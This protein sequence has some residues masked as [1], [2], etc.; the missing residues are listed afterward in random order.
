MRKLIFILGLTAGASLWGCGRDWLAENPG[1]CVFDAECLEG[2]RCINGECLRLTIEQPDGGPSLKEFGERCLANEECRSSYCLSHPRG[3]FCTRPCDSGCPAGFVCREVADP[4]GGPNTVALCAPDEN[5]LC[6]P[7]L[8]HR[9]CGVGGADLCL[10]FPE[11]RFCTRDCSAAPCPAGY[12]CRDVEISAQRFRQCLPA[13]GTC[14]CDESSAG[15]VRGCSVHNDLGE[16]FGVETC[17]P[18]AGFTGCS[19]TVPA[20]EEC[21]GLDDDCDGFADEGLD[22]VPCQTSNA[23]GT[24]TGTR[25]CRGFDGLYCDAPEPAAEI[26]N[27]LDD[28]C[29]GATDEDFRDEAG[30][31]FRPEH[32]GGCNRDCDALLLHAS[33]TECRRVGEEFVCR[34]LSCE[35]G[36]YRAADDS[37]CLPLPDTLCDP[38]QRDADCLG[39]GSLCLTLDGER[40]CGRDCSPASQYPPGCPAGYVCQNVGS[41]LQCQPQT[42]TCLCTTASEGAIRSCRF[43]TCEG[44]QVCRRDAGGYAWSICDVDSYNPEIC[45]GRD[46][47]CDGRTDEGF[48]NPVTG[49]YESPE[50]CGT[51]NN[52][53]SRYFV[54]ELDHTTGVCDLGQNPPRCGMGPCLTESEGGVTYEWVNL[55]NDP[56]NG[57]ECRRRLGNT[58]QDEPDLIG[59]PVPGLSYLDENC[60]GID[61][62]I[63]RALFARPGSV[64]G[65]GSR[66][67]PFGSLTQALAALPASGKSYVLAA[68]GT[69]EETVG[70][71]ALARLHGGYS[72]DFS[73]RDVVLY[74]SVIQAPAGGPA[75]SASGVQGEALLSGF[76]VR[77]RDLAPSATGADGAPSVAIRLE[78]CGPGLTIRSTVVWAGRGG[79]GG[80][81]AAGAAGFGRQNSVEL[82]GGAGLDGLREY[83]PCPAGRQLA[84]GRAGNNPSCLA[85][86]GRSGGT[87]V[88]PVYDYPNKQGAQAQYPVS[89]FGNGLGGYDWSFDP[90]SGSSCSHATESGFPDR[91]QLNVGQDGQNGADGSAGVGGAGGVGAFGSLCGTSW[92]ASPARALAGANGQAAAGG[93]G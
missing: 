91:I 11:G 61:G 18:P 52:D 5:R 93:G 42:R 48:R 13:G 4:H 80:A 85:A 10:S 63:D 15:L 30:R 7:C 74:P 24:C 70:L 29:D 8:E 40:F 26:C 71:T 87:T 50:H 23:F 88:C 51:C 83:A 84:G 81:G 75:V 31:F 9:N 2:F 3:A 68:E 55:D 20:A 25:T 57:C 67:R 59:E 1:R 16:C 58:T 35:S 38:C 82:D 72:A 19:A 17:T 56:S 46:N 64:G 89:D 21:N 66:Q 36:F 12:Q 47:N 14:A 49:R 27:S 41:A 53:C 92:C 34:V 65:D 69:Y 33:R 79:N 39:P 6:Q 73:N 22:P 86:S 28:D 37:A 32:C 76:V 77:G 60:D 43:Q 54:P 78:N 44:Y 45:D 90:Y 62:V